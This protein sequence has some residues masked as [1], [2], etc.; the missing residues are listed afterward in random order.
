M[1]YKFKEI[2]TLDDYFE[3]FGLKPKKEDI[4]RNGEFKAKLNC[5]GTIA[6]ALELDGIAEHYKPYKLLFNELDS[7]GLPTFA[8]YLAGFSKEE[9]EFYKFTKKDYADF[10]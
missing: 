1:D 6:F 10:R 2:K 8:E 9:H 3:D 7:Q 5:L 4:E